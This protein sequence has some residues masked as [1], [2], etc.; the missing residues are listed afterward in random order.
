MIIGNLILVR[1]WFQSAR[2]GLPIRCRRRIASWGLPRKAPAGR[3]RE[4][5]KRA[6]AGI[7]NYLLGTF[8]E[9]AP[10]PTAYGAERAAIIGSA[11]GS[12]PLGKTIPGR[13]PTNETNDR[14]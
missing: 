5:H 2:T 7:R 3:H 13:G 6:L 9:A 8:R 11:E 1:Q 14:S 4:R 10:K 12:T